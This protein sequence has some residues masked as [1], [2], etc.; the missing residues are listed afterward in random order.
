MQNKGFLDFIEKLQAATSGK[1][2][3]PNANDK[4]NDKNNKSGE[5]DAIDESKSGAANA[6][7]S[8]GAESGDV[9]GGSFAGGNTAGRSFASG[10]LTSYSKTDEKSYLKTYN[11][12]G[13]ALSPRPQIAA[14]RAKKQPK[15]KIDLSLGKNLA[16]EKKSEASKNMLD[17]IKRHNA[18]SRT[19][20]NG[21][22]SY[23]SGSNESDC[24]A[25]AAGIKSA[26]NTADAE[27]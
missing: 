27:K 10:G 25:N 12:F 14:P 17:L 4:N 9:R 20:K 18:A 7:K 1:N 26:G 5:S 2:N 15:E 13:D 8:G 16:G 3:Y 19:I 6:R 11:P 23:A 21:G 24:G 22:K